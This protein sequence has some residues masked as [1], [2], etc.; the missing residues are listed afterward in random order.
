M[1]KLTTWFTSRHQAMIWGI[2]RFTNQINYFFLPAINGWDWTVS[3]WHY[4]SEWTENTPNFSLQAVETENKQLKDLLKKNASKWRSDCTWT[5][6][7]QAILSHSAFGINGG[8]R[9]MYEN[10]FDLRVHGNIKSLYIIEKKN[11]LTSSDRL[12][13]MKRQSE[14]ENEILRLVSM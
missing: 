14:R 1:S 8:R 10:L 6:Q 4:D 3:I 9:Q 13:W 12:I 2:W 5:A 11:Q 7:L